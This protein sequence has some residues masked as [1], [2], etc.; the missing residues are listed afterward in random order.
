MIKTMGKPCTVEIRIAD[1]HL[2][3][4]NGWIVHGDFFILEV[5]MHRPRREGHL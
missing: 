5:E 3:E 2:S 1:Q 4:A